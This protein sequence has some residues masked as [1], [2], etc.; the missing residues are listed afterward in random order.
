MHRDHI[1]RL[2]VISR[3]DKHRRL[4]LVKWHPDLTY[5]AQPSGGG[6]LQWAQAWKSHYEDGDILGYLRLEGSDKP[7]EVEVVHQ[8]HLVLVD[9]PAYRANLVGVLR[10]WEQYI[11]GWIL[12]RIF[13]VANGAEPP[14]IVGFATGEQSRP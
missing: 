8:M 10:E 2:N 3:I 5:W 1:N 11:G 6:D 14:L 9:D 12:P 7:P 4:P 13:A